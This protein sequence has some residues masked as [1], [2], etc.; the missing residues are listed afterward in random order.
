[1]G[2]HVLFTNDYFTIFEEDEKVRLK[3]SETGYNFGDFSEEV[4]AKLP[5]LKITKFKALRAAFEENV[6]TDVE[7]GELSS[8]FTIRVSKD[9]LEAHITLHMTEEE[10]EHTN[11]AH[12]K[13]AIEIE[14]AKQGIEYSTDLDELL[15]TITVGE[16][17]LMAKGI[18]PIDGEDAKI[19]MYEV[20]EI[21]PEI[22][23]DDGVDH[24]ELNI[25]NK[26][27]EDEWLGERIEPTLGT[28]GENIYKKPV[29]AKPGEQ[30]ALKYDVK[31]VREVLADDGKSTILKAMYSG[32]VIFFDEEV[33]VLN[34]VEIEGSVGYS[35]GN[36]DFN[37]FVEIT[38]TV[39]DNFSVVADQTV[40]IDGKMGVGAC[41]LIESRK[42][43][44][45]IKGGVA[46]KHHAVIRAKENIY[47]K[48]AADCT[49][50]CEGTL[51][52]GFYAMNCK[53][54]A[55]EVIGETVDSRII[56]GE[57][58]ADIRIEAGS[59]GSKAHTK[60]YLKV[61]GFNK[62]KLKEDYDRLYKG[63]EITKEKIKKQEEEVG[64][65]DGMDISPVVAEKKYQLK[66]EIKKKKEY[67]NVLY[68]NQ[69]KYTGYLLTKGNGE[70]KAKQKVY[71]NVYM[72]VSGKSHEIK[73]E[74]N[75]STIYYIE[76]DE[77]KEE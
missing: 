73:E 12:L 62:Q 37:G 77:W 43:D 25:I 6:T 13:D 29:K 56:G 24:Y 35:T 48:F 70:I 68:A 30:K 9:L 36:I 38:D 20:K 61:L 53:I 76:N 71:P 57:V 55:K 26:V 14:I 23:N 1:M 66:R 65:Y 58:T 50:E 22:I 17:Y 15:D 5:R 33:G 69:K 32:A 72:E 52:I 40:Q 16:P 27:L 74:K 39:E 4:V 42:G 19:T 64:K 54:K 3:I 59:L 75:I 7:I 60:T 51:N 63:I 46:G 31:S 44:V 11:M 8:I 10:L 18:A 28:D 21:K 47:L 34:S 49:I 41:E 67:L 2:Y 45:V